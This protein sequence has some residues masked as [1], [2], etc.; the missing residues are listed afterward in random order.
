[1][2]LPSVAIHGVRQCKAITKRSKKRSLNPSAY[3][4][5]TCRY[6]GANPVHT[7]KNVAGENHPN[8]KNGI[9]TK[10]TKAERSNRSVTLRHLIDLGNHTNSFYKQ[11]KGRGRPPSGYTR[12]DL[13]DPKQL[14]LVILKIR[15]K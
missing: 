3:G 1:M 13:T 2:P 14:S 4:C 15:P 11:L 5:S 9:W 12:L 8:F 10:E 6:H 7:R